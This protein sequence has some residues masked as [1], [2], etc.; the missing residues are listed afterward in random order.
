MKSPYLCTRNLTKNCEINIINIIKNYLIMKKIFTLFAGLMLAAGA[1]AQG[2]YSYK[3]RVVNGNMEG[4]QDESWSSFWCHEFR[5]GEEGQFQGFARII[6]DPTDPTNHCAAV[7][8][9]SEAEA[10]E[11]G[12]KTALDDGTLASW[13][14][15]FFVYVEEPIY[16]NQQVKLTMR[17]RAE[18][19]AKATTQ[20]HANPGNYNHY[21]GIGDIEFTTEWVEIEREITVDTS[22]SQWNE[23]EDPENVSKCM[24]SIAFNLA[25]FKEGNT[26]YFDDVKM[27]VRTPKPPKDLTGWFDLIHNGDLSTDDVRCFTEKNGD[28]A[29]DFEPYAAKI[30]ND[31]V[32]GQRTLRVMSVPTYE[33]ITGSTGE[34]ELQDWN[35]QYFITTTHKFK[36]GEKYKFSMQ[37][38][39]DF[40]I[41]IDTQIHHE[42]GQ[43]LYY[44]LMGSFNLTTEWQEF[45][46]EGTID[47]N[48]NGGYTIAF[49]CNKDREQ[50]NYMY[51]RNIKFEINDAEATDK[52]REWGSEEI[53]CR[54]ADGLGSLAIDMANATK[55]LGFEETAE[56]YIYELSTKVL[57]P[58]GESEDTEYTIEFSAADG[59]NIDATGRFNEAGG[60]VI[61]LDQAEGDV[62]TFNVEDMED[63]LAGD[64]T[65][66]TRIAIAKDGKHYVYYVTLLGATAEDPTGVKTVVAKKADG[67]IYDLSGRRVQNPVK[68][69]YIKDGKKFILK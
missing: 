69:L 56:N 15:Q 52:D 18:K 37:A 53:T 68:G 26:Y 50:I 8:A 9:R 62:V 31:P 63:L 12:N 57:A 49:N 36:T 19:A 25:E 43:Y 47:S 61:S 59:F 23:E 32:D 16:P 22:Q 3:D 46:A 65:V 60:I 45:T 55:E 58:E 35:A 13:D 27:E 40:P 34:S 5:E 39:A 42:P 24:Y 7:Y 48:Q 38:R 10:D 21:I 66:N 54:V 41:A 29:N 20:A 44:A 17:V 64:A 67:V 30:Y 14:S 33:Q 11:A 51:F 6:E 2:E 1:F 4:E 28:T